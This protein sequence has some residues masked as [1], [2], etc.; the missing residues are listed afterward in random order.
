MTFWCCEWRRVSN[1]TLFLHRTDLPKP[2]R[3]RNDVSV[4]RESNP[5]PTAYT[6]AVNQGTANST[7]IQKRVHS[8]NPETSARNIISV[9]TKISDLHSSKTA[10]SSSLSYV[11]MARY[12]LIFFLTKY[13]IWIIK[14]AKKKLNYISFKRTLLCVGVILWVRLHKRCFLFFFSF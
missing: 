12:I 13:F 5:F 10:A 4:L 1:L 14:G 11:V 3:L 6:L 2:S 7:R 8:H 9:L